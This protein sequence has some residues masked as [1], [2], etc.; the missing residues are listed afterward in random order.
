MFVRYVEPAFNSLSDSLFSDILTSDR[1]Q[2]VPAVDIVELNDRYEIVSEL[3]GLK[4]ED[5][6]IGVDNGTLTISGE[7]KH[8]G[9]P[10][11]TTVLRHETTTQPFSRSFGIPEEVNTNAISA[12]LKDGLLR[13]QMPK[14]EKARPQEISIR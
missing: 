9:F 1:M 3:P 10:E 12:E 7:R 5:L 6:K 2:N 13:I 4:K 14:S 11:G 8:Y